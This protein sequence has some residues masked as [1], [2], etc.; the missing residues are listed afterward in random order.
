[1]GQNLTKIPPYTLYGP[2]VGPR[3][4]DLTKT[5]AHSTRE[6]QTARSSAWSVS[7][8]PKI[9]R[10]G[11]AVPFSSPEL[12]VAQPLVGCSRRS[13]PAPPPARAVI[14]MKVS[15]GGRLFSS[16]LLP[17]WLGGWASLWPCRPCA[18]RNASV[19]DLL[20]IAVEGCMHGELDK[21]YD[22]LRELEKAEGVKI[23][24]LLCCGDFQVSR[25]CALRFAA[26]LFLNWEVLR[27]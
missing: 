9:L 20:Q 3:I 7:S 21:V 25:P 6:P 17:F 8:I 2:D 12:R 1:M 14:T 27:N 22:T 18:R 5:A 26:V 15:Q 11:A 10:D 13:P 24:L 16:V 4:R 19:G 23:D